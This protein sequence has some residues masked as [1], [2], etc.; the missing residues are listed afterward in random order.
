MTPKQIELV[1]N[2]WDFILLNTQEAGVIFYG[3]LFEL[4]PSLKALFKE[5]IKSQSQKLVALITFAV[6]KLNNI[7]DIV[8]DV[9]ALG[10]RHKKYN[11]QP[12]HY[13]TVAT[14]LLWT[15]EAGLKEQWNDE[16]KSAWVA[17][18]T[19]LSNTMIEAGK[20]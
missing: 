7:N 12:A 1:E 14:A 5:D 6:H 10:Q 2:S 8:A 18:Y 19:I 13:A 16:L 9:K 17:V 15:L 20:G 11:V 3:K 4:D